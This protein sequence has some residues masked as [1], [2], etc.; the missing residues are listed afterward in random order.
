MV[1]ETCRC[2][3]VYEVNWHLN[4]TPVTN[5]K[6]CVQCGRPLAGWYIQT[7][8]P[9]YTLIIS[10]ERRTVPKPWAGALDSV[11]CRADRLERSAYAITD[12]ALDL[13]AGKFHEDIG[14]VSEETL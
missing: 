3:A 12:C 4:P 5:H 8:W 9:E 1:K 2:G 6:D 7:K 11:L 14:A 13:D 10:S